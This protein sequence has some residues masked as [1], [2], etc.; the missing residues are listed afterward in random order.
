VNPAIV[1]IRS[2]LVYGVTSGDR[3]QIMCL[4]TDETL[5]KARIAL[6][7]VETKDD[8]GK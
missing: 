3:Y 7:V 2:R 6:S 8:K 5:E 4:D 1:S